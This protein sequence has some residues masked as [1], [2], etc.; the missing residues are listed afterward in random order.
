MNSSF[1]AAECFNAVAFK[2]KNPWKEQFLLKLTLLTF[3]YDFLFHTFYLPYDP[4][5]LPPWLLSLAVCVIF[6]SALLFSF[7]STF[8]ISLFHILWALLFHS[9]CKSFNTTG[10][11]T[12]GFALRTKLAVFKP[13]LE[14]KTFKYTL[15]RV[16]E[17][18]VC[19]HFT[20]HSVM[21]KQFPSGRCRLFYNSLIEHFLI[22]N[23]LLVWFHKLSWCN[24]HDLK[25]FSSVTLKRKVLIS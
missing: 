24:L 3:D 25:Y 14:K 1:K 8:Q 23:V 5:C 6:S 16:L 11:F 19:G 20:G 4:S 21:L 18:A 10:I 15:A 22:P 9:S 17:T 2:K 7:Y 12:S 13:L